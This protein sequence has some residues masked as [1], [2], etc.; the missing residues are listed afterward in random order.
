MRLTTLKSDS[1][2]WQSFW[3]DFES[4][5]QNLE[6]FLA[7]V[8]VEKSDYHFYYEAFVHRSASSESSVQGIPWNERLEF[9]GDS[10][11]GLAVSTHLWNTQG[12]VEE[13]VLSTQRSMLVSRTALA[14]LARRLSLGACLALG[15]G[16]RKQKAWEQD[17]LLANV[18]EAFIGAMYLHRGYEKT[19]EWITE[20]YGQQPI[21]ES[22][23]RDYKTY[24]QEWVQSLGFPTPSYQ[25]ITNSGPSHA[26]TFEMAVMVGEKELARA[27]SSSKK[28]ASQMAAELALK[29]LEEKREIL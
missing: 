6:T 25:V 16:E 8:G 17:S 29:N 12:R 26:P 4:V 2:H 9:L 10:V 3:K 19:A 27:Q 20:L 15:C 28:R 11:L 13:G 7:S 21:E 1:S 24:L 18:M 22:P 5:F 14:S 23:R